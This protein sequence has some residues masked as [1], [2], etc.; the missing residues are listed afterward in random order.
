MSPT[1]DELLGLTMALVRRLRSLGF[2]A[3]ADALMAALTGGCSAPEL[4][5][6][7]R[8]EL[9]DLIEALPPELQERALSLVEQLTGWLEEEGY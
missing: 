1:L 8:A 2:Q 7:L 9:L 3:E 4:V 5:H 6:S